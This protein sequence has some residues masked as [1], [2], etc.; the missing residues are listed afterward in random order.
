MMY[1]LECLFYN[2]YQILSEKKKYFT[3][4][5]DIKI[6]CFKTSCKEVKSSVCTYRRHF[7]AYIYL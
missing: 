7:V 6:C 1:V 5:S 3:N 4:V 2:I